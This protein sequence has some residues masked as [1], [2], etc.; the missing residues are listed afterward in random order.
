MITT[1]NLYGALRL[2]FG[3]GFRADINS[4]KEAVEFLEMA[5]PG[6][7]Q[8]ILRMRKHVFRV[9]VGKKYII[10]EYLPLPSNGKSISITPILE[11]TANDKGIW[12]IIAGVVLVIAGAV[13]AYYTGDISII[14]AGIGLLA[15][16]ISVLLAPSPPGQEPNKN[17]ASYIFTNPVNSQHQGGPVP[18]LVGELII[19]SSVISADIAAK[20]I[21]S[22]SSNPGSGTPHGT[23]SSNVPGS[24]STPAWWHDSAGA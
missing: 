7:R 21:E 18:Y 8:Q 23:G 12:E 5:R 4:P 19:G 9:R 22:G 11:G 6:F 16:G 14:L 17:R 2:K 1:I 3:T 20:D 15:G 10:G 24:F 13:Y